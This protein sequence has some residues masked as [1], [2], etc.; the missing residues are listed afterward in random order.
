MHSVVDF[1]PGLYYNS[2][3]ASPKKQC[4]IQQEK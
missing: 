4:E 2:T 3:K 1:F